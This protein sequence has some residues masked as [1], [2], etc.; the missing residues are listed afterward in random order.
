[1]VMNKVETDN[2][3]FMSFLTCNIPLQKKGNAIATNQ[4][5]IHDLSLTQFATPTLGSNGER[6]E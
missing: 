2:L 1:M 6:L 4:G 5:V 3:L